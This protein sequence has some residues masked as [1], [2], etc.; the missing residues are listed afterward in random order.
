MGITKKSLNFSINFLS[1]DKIT[2]YKEAYKSHLIRYNSATKKSGN[3]SQPIFKSKD[4]KNT[5]KTKNMGFFKKAFR[6]LS[7]NFM[8]YA[9][10]TNPINKSLI[11]NEINPK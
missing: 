4:V 5:A 2:A 10:T 8:K 1:N 3:P 9:V 6:T 7:L 11:E